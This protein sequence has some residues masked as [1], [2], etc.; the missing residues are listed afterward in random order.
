MRLVHSNHLNAGRIK[1]HIG[2]C[3]NLLQCL[4]QGAEGRGLDRANLKEITIVVGC[5]GNGGRFA[6]LEVV[7][8]ECFRLSFYSSVWSAFCPF[9]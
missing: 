3:Q 8:L 6:Q 4:N 7:R 5:R 1:L 2:L 9:V